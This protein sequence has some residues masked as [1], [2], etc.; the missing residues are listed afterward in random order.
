MGVVCIYSQSQAPVDSLSEQLSSV[1]SAGLFIPAGAGLPAG[2][3]FS[4][5]LAPDDLGL[6]PVIRNRFHTLALANWLK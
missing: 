3:D 2:D 5:S 6:H 4:F 1:K